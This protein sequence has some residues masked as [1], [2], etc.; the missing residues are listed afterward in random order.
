MLKLFMSGNRRQN[1]QLPRAKRMKVFLKPRAPSNL[2]S[3]PNTHPT[4]E[5]WVHLCI[6][7]YEIS[8]AN[9]EVEWYQW[10]R[11]ANCL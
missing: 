8:G 4:T 3:T 11:S 6:R 7:Y 5:P 10:E 1:R 9:S 2:G